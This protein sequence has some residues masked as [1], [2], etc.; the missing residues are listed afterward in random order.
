MIKK[1]LALLVAIVV[2][3]GCTACGGGGAGKE[4]V[5]VNRTQ[6]YV[7]HFAGGFGSEWLTK[8][9][10][11]FEEEYKDV[12]FEEGKVG[13]QVILDNHKLIGSKQLAAI[14][15]NANYIFINE[16]VSYW[17]VVKTSSALDITDVVTG[18]FDINKATG[19]ETIPDILD[20]ERAIVNKFTDLQKASLKIDNKYYTIPHYEAYNGFTYDAE[21]FNKNNYFL[22]DN[23]DYTN[24]NS[25]LT[26]S[27]GPDGV[28]GTYDDGLPATY[29]EF[30]LLCEIMISDGVIPMVWSGEWEMYITQ[31]IN[32]LAVD[33]NGYANEQ[34]AYTFNGT[35]TSWIADW[36]EDENGRIAPGAGEKKI[37]N[38]NG[39]ET[40]NTEGY[41]YALDWLERITRLAGA[42]HD[43]SYVDSFSHTGAQREFMLSSRELS[44]K[45][46]AM[47][48]EGIWWE[49]ESASFFTNMSNR[50]PNSGIQDRDFRF[51]PMPK[52][53][54]DKVGKT[55]LLESNN[56]YTFIKANTP[57][58]YVPLCKLFV[59]YM[60]TTARLQQFTVLTNT[61]KAL[62]YE[63][64]EEQMNALTPFGRSILEMKNAE[65]NGEKY[66][67]VL[68]Q[69]SDNPFYLRN[70]TKLK[71]VDV[72]GKGT[73]LWPSVTMHNNLNTNVGTAK[74]YFDNFFMSPWKTGWSNLQAN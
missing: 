25:G 69:V 42:V 58:K 34:L 60:N 4:I 28:K 61:P 39:Y 32:Q 72:F 30:F 44:K 43:N 31:A 46:I 8:I 45:P 13:V 1:L 27:A 73:Q 15:G 51:M 63:L 37:E 57:E 3:F 70:R 2:L 71:R 14:L 17:D 52:A 36:T 56:A 35:S 66:T 18:T 50:Y 48:A 10:L 6:I 23:G 33:A 47:L 19:D 55:T 26:L 41:F 54:A 9:K 68:Y 64:T 29:D 5:D 7:S 59:Q 65:V 53:T 49:N 38:S 11:D 22:A 16:D 74:Y 12:S 62:M 67:Q 21:L 40:F 24:E 20:S